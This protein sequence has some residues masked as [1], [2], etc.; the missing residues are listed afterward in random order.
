[1]AFKC[2][3]FCTAKLFISVFMLVVLANDLILMQIDTSSLIHLSL[4]LCLMIWMKYKK[5]DGGK[6]HDE[7][8]QWYF[9]FTVVVFC[10]SNCD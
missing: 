1:M 7:K 10:L 4:S 5:T 8:L 6:I 9:Y 3:Q 2:A